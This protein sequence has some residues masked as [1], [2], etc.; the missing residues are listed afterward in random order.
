MPDPGFVFQRKEGVVNE[1]WNSQH[2]GSTE[3]HTRRRVA[4]MKGGTMMALGNTARG[5]MA[6]GRRQ[7][8]AWRWVARRRRRQQGAAWQDNKGKGWHDSKGQDSC[9]DGGTDG[10]TSRMA[11]ALLMVNFV[12]CVNGISGGIKE[13]GG[14]LLLSPCIRCGHHSCPGIFIA[15]SSLYGVRIFDDGIAFDNRRCNE[16]DASARLAQNMLSK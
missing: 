11:A 9:H 8:A 6:G 7:G 3:G 4:S 14:A 2:D 10:G 13:G 15:P 1:G 16:Q 5:S 12:G